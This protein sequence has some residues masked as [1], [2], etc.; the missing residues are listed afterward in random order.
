MVYGCRFLVLLSMA[1]HH[2]PGP[3]VTPATAQSWSMVCCFLVLLSAMDYGLWLMIGC[4]FNFSHDWP[5]KSIVDPQMIW[6]RSHLRVDVLTIDFVNNHVVELHMISLLF[7]FLQASL[8]TERK[9]IS[10]QVVDCLFFTQVSKIRDWYITCFSLQ[11]KLH[12][13]IQD[14]TVFQTQPIID[15]RL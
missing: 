7:F 9:E 1:G 15:F 5:Q 13:E 12:L 8:R 4:E 11:D 14:A 2:S 6:N 10:K 3:F